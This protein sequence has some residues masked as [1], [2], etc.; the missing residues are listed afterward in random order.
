MTLR[1]VLDTNIWL[2]WLVFADPGIQS[3]RVAVEQGSVTIFIDEACLE[4]L[5]RVLA[6]PLRR[7]PLDSTE[8]AACI[9][10]CRA[11]ARI[12]EPGP[13]SSSLPAC[14]DPDDQKFLE[15][16]DRADAHYLLSKDRA[17]LA[18]A[19]KR[20]IKFHIMTPDRFSAL[21]SLES[22]G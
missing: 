8:Q 16:A 9:A 21:K 14:A 17:L 11:H 13:A 7:Q 4:E 22:Q 5:A 1:L 12:V 18:L 10:A 15:L 6:Y 2:D 3:L 19:R 20:A